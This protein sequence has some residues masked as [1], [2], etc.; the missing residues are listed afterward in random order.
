MVLNRTNYHHYF[1]ISYGF[2]DLDLCISM[3]Q[4]CFQ[5]DG[6]MDLFDF[7]NN[8]S[9]LYDKISTVRMMVEAFKILHNCNISHRDIK[10]ENIMVRIDRENDNAVVDL[11]VIDFGLSDTECENGQSQK[12]G[13]SL[14]F[15]PLEIWHSVK[16]AKSYDPFAADVWSLG[17]TIFT[18]FYNEL[19]FNH[20]NDK[21]QYLNILCNCSNRYR[22]AVDVIDR[23]NLNLYSFELEQTILRFISVML[24]FNPEERSTLEEIWAKIPDQ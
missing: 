12:L 24:Y 1:N 18:V 15:I 2:N 22:N 7:N 21:E 5:C 14:G 23:M 8:F 3:E 6:W 10:P 9:Q 19:I 11:K 17:I 20:Y 13:G 16:Y 4:L